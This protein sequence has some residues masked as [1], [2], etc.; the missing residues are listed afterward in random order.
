[1]SL[2][3]GGMLRV[4][5]D[6]GEGRFRFS[7]NDMGASVSDD[8]M[9]VH[10]GLKRKVKVFGDDSLLI[11]YSTLQSENNKERLQYEYSVEFSPFRIRQRINE[12]ET[13]VVNEFDNLMFEKFLPD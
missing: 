1:M 7:Q 12:I 11:S 2:Y 9:N 4:A 10:G 5:I 8:L 6:E 3:E 13:M